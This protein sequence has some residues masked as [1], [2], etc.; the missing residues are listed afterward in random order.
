MSTAKKTALAAPKAKLPVLAPDVMLRW[1]LGLAAQSNTLGGRERIESAP[2]TA[3]KDALARRERSASVTR[4]RLME[5]DGAPIAKFLKLDL[6]SYKLDIAQQGAL[7][8]GYQVAQS[9]VAAL[10]AG[11]P[12]S[13]KARRLARGLVMTVAQQ[14]LE[15]GKLP[16][17]QLHKLA[18]LVKEG[19][20]LAAQTVAGQQAGKDRVAGLNQHFG[21]QIDDVKAHGR[22]FAALAAIRRGESPGWD[23][24][25]EAARAYDQLVPAPPEPPSSDRRNNQRPGS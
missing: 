24:L 5:G 9:I 25:V 2:A 4:M 20:Q 16:P 6:A 3:P 13:D 21:V 19:R 11:R 15:E 22:V 1:G 10:R 7:Y 23:Q 8:T 18:R 17:D 14:V 12:V